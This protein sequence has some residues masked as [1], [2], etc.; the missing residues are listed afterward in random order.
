MTPVNYFTVD[1]EEWFHGLT[2]ASRR[3]ESWSRY[4][5]RAAVGGEWLLSALERAGVKATFF[6]VGLVA[7][8]TPGIV[9]AIADAGHEIGL[10]GHTHK[11]VREM[12]REGFAAD[13]DEGIA[14]LKEA[15]GTAPAG[16]RAPCFSVDATTPWLW[17]ELAARGVKYDSSVFPIRAMLYG[18][19]G[20]G[21]EPFVKQTPHGPIHEFPMT[22][23]RAGGVNLPFSGG[24]YLRALPYALTRTLIQRLNAQG[25]PV[26]I[27]CHPWEFDPGHPVPEYVTVRERL[28]HYGFLQDARDKYLRLLDDFAFA[29]LGRAL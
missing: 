3:P 28:S 10:H 17:E 12:A 6:I 26:I 2:S 18:Y 14:A 22:V 13:L 5:R 21:R 8:E 16:F 20:G 23:Y 24:F 25:T 11:L 19:P 27:Y 29:P 15:T 1:F 4:E 7:R 9:R